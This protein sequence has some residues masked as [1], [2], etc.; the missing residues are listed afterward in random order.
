MC[1]H[2]S[3]SYPARAPSVQNTQ[4][5]PQPMP[6]LQFQLSCHGAFCVESLRTHLLAP[7]SISAVLPGYLLCREPRDLFSLCLLQLSCKDTLYADSPKSTPT[8]T[9]FSS[10]HPTRV[11]PT[12][13]ALGPPLTTSYSSNQPVKVLRYRVYTG[14]TMQI[15]SNVGEIAVLPD[16]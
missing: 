2:F 10:G 14:I 12:W 8:H 9:H 4:G 6:T 15:P 11:V 16:S 5:P 13:S 7:T 3:F 1:T